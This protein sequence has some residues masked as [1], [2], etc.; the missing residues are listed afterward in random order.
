MISGTLRPAGKGGSLLDSRE[1]PDL[2]GKGRGCTQL[3]SEKMQEKVQLVTSNLVRWGDVRVAIKIRLRIAHLTMGIVESSYA[4]IAMRWKR[5]L[6]RHMSLLP[7][8]CAFSGGRGCAPMCLLISFPLPARNSVAGDCRLKPPAMTPRLSRRCVSPER[9]GLKYGHVCVPPKRCPCARG[10][11]L[12]Q[13][14]LKPKLASLVSPTVR[15]R[16]SP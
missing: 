7:S 4:S 10:L 12:S 11:G 1:T 3:N 16:L 13:P 6:L 15:V 8:V 9:D 2:R 14:D 5:R